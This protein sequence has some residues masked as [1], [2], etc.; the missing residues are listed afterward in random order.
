MA[1]KRRPSLV[2]SFG[3]IHRMPPALKEEFDRRLREGGFA[4]HQELADWL[5]QQGI[6]VSKQAIHAYGRKFEEQLAAIRLATEQARE[7]CAQFEGD[8]KSM[9][10]ALLRLV[11]TQLFQ[12]LIAA[13]ERLPAG[14]KTGPAGSL[15]LSAVARSVAGLVRAEAEHRK[16]TEHAREKIAAAGKKIDEAR[17]HGL[18]ERGADEIRRV[19]MEIEP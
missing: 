8:E 3:K 12:V 4:G 17:E 5:S 1:S 11:Q 19:L 6:A 2:A 10:E 16:W 15:N 7:V 14:A 13:N 9:Q 18:S